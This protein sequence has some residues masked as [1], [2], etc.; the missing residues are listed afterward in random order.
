MADAFSDLRRRIE[1]YTPFHQELM[2]LGDLLE[3]AG[4][5][6]VC[7]QPT[8]AMEMP[9]VHGPIV[10]PGEHCTVACTP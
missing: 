6:R 1:A 5:C 2:R 7:G 3:A 9:H 8:H 4:R 10:H